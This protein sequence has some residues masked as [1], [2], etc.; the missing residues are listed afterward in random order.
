MERKSY[1]LPLATNNPRPPPYL[2]QSN[3]QNEDQKTAFTTESS[4]IQMPQIE[5]NVFDENKWISSLHNYNSNNQIARNLEFLDLTLNENRSTVE[6]S[7]CK[8]SILN[9][10]AQFDPKFSLLCKNKPDV[11]KVVL[12]NGVIM[13]LK[14]IKV[15]EN[16]SININE[17]HREY[18]NNEVVA[19]LCENA[20]KTIDMKIA[21]E[22]AN[23]FFEILLEYGGENVEKN[24]ASLQINE[25][26]EIFYQL[27]NTLEMLTSFGISHMD[28]KPLNMVYDKTKSLLKIIDFGSSISFYDSPEKIAESL[29]DNFQK[30]HSFTE[31]FAPP[32]VLV[33]ASN[34]IN[35]QYLQAR[36][37]PEKVDIFCFGITFAKLLA[38][39]RG[40]SLPNSRTYEKES[41]NTFLYQLE[42][43]LKELNLEYPQ[44]IKIILNCLPF[45]PEERLSFKEVKSSFDN[46]LPPKLLECY[47]EKYSVYDA[48]KK[49]SNFIKLIRAKMQMKAAEAVIWYCN[50]FITEMHDENNT[51]NLAEVKYIQGLAYA[52]MLKFDNAISVLKESATINERL[53]KTELSCL[54]F[55]ELAEIYSKKN[56]IPESN[57]IALNVL[58]IISKKNGYVNLTVAKSFKILGS[59][60]MIT[61]KFNN[62]RKYLY[63]SMYIFQKLSGETSHE[64]AVSYSMLGLFFH[65]IQDYEMS[66]EYYTK[67]INIILKMGKNYKALA[68]LFSN[69]ALDCNE[70]GQYDLAIKWLLKGIDHIKMHHGED[71]PSLATLYNNLAMSHKAQGHFTQ[72]KIEYTTAL[73][74]YEKIYGKESQACAQAIFNLGATNYSLLLKSE[75]IEH[76]NQAIKICKKIFPYDLKFLAKCYN[77][78]GIIS[79]NSGKLKEAIE[80]FDESLRIYEQISGEPDTFDADRYCSVCDTLRFKGEFKKAEEYLLK[81]IEIYKKVYKGPHQ[82][83]ANAF[84]DLFHIYNSMG[85]YSK[86][87]NCKKHSDELMNSLNSQNFSTP[88][89][90]SG[91][92]LIMS[93]YKNKHNEGIEKIKAKIEKCKRMYTGIHPDLATLHSDLGLLYDLQSKFDDAKS[94]YFLALEMYQKLQMTETPHYAITLKKLGSVFYEER[95]YDHA[96][97]NYT[98]ALSIFEEIYKSQNGKNP[99]IASTYLD[100]GLAYRDKGELQTGIE[101]MKKC[102]EISNIFFEPSHEKMV[103]LYSQMRMTYLKMGDMENYRRYTKLQVRPYKGY[104]FIG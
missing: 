36:I 80:F 6:N 85:N 95:K 27:I 84:L 104:T 25:L 89:N 98:R 45:N 88:I 60:F 75:A 70:I 28:L 24:I 100:L 86:A 68:T 40:K 93:H 32:E 23:I 8:T 18:Y 87:E 9:P 52:D 29:G 79:L 77:N 35:R 34:C 90:S 16:K 11:V 101:C 62:A 72:A 30:I 33:W 5:N 38:L 4:S 22:G 50:K 37:K 78:L 12:N 51:A 15:N 76:Y 67:C 48:S 13:V 92:D 3:S 42:N 14:K 73:Q 46:A 57:K 96:I 65:E 2:A 97:E 7:G 55:L 58:K 10:Y 49:Q 41:H 44:W 20:V 63:H 39:A 17:A 81:A 53:E 31:E 56:N 47:R 94:E 74:M 82:K 43:L 61:K 69:L 71:S 26:T 54:A 103:I 19:S 83:I 59:N 64:V 99:D 1:D 102:E 21:K 66:I 91:A